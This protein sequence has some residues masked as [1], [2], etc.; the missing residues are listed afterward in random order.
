[1]KIAR[2]RWLDYLVWYIAYLLLYNTVQLNISIWFVICTK[3]FQIFKRSDKIR[4]TN[5]PPILALWNFT[6]HICYLF[7]LVN[8]FTPGKDG[9]EGKTNPVHLI[10]I[11]IVLRFLQ[12]GGSGNL[13][14]LSLWLYAIFLFIIFTGRCGVSQSEKRYNFLT[15]EKMFRPNR[16]YNDDVWINSFTAGIFPPFGLILFILLEAEHKLYFVALYLFLLFE[17][18]NELHTFY[19]LTVKTMR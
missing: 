8:Y 16:W 14:I 5:R 3:T 7:F 9:L 1:M 18:M 12:G 11:Y 17:W 6:T 2:L 10:I 13:L 19:Y 15:H 4:A